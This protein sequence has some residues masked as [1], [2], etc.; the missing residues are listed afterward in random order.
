MVRP[1]ASKENRLL[2]L[3]FVKACTRVTGDP[4]DLLARCGPLSPFAALS[5]CFPS[6]VRVE[7]AGRRDGIT[8]LECNKVLQTGGFQMIRDRRA[9]AKNKN[10]DPFGS[11]LY[12]YTEVQWRDP[13]NSEDLLHISKAWESM[14]NQFQHLAAECTLEVLVSVVRDMLSTWKPHQS[15]KDVRARNRKRKLEHSDSCS[16]M[17]SIMSHMTRQESEMSLASTIA[18][19][20]FSDL[21]PETKTFSRRQSLSWADEGSVFEADCDFP[22][23]KRQ[24]FSLESHNTA[25]GPAMNT[26]VPSW[27]PSSEGIPT[28]GVQYCDA[29]WPQLPEEERVDDAVVMSLLQRI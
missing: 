18:D 19:E 17:S 14:C 12:L 23:S 25:L 11:G 16:S 8:E 10:D 15:R 1:C 24:Y 2:C 20:D 6:S 4:A 9:S 29:V 7:G 3:E 5:R 22:P 21:S 28:N 13:D 27:Q 26:S